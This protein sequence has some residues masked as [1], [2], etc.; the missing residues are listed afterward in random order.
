MTPRP[1]PCTTALRQQ[2]VLYKTGHFFNEK[3]KN[4]FSVCSN[5]LSPINRLVTMRVEY[6]RIYI[7]HL[8]SPEGQRLDLYLTQ[9]NIC[10]NMVIHYRW[11]NRTILQSIG[12]RHSEEYLENACVS[13]GKSFG[14]PVSLG[15]ESIVWRLIAVNHF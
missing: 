14:F 11:K 4:I 7:F 1:D 3:K 2:N 9:E 12:V 8:K 10:L 13:T 5:F 6:I 15:R